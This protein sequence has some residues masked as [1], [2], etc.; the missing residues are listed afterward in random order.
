MPVQYKYL[1][2]LYGIRNI[3][4]AIQ[5]HLPDHCVRGRQ[6]GE[7]LFSILHLLFSTRER[8][9]GCAEPAE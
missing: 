8:E 2:G 3:R 7:S 1:F 5:D 4:N 6:V 9:R